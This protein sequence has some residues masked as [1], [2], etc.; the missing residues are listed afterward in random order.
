MVV[1]SNGWSHDVE[2][3]KRLWAVS[4]EHTGVVC[5]VA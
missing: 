5:P 4:E 1:V 3:L 2:V